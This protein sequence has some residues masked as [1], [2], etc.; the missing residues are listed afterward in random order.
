M[1][2]ALSWLILFYAITIKHQIDLLVG[3]KST[4]ACVFGAAF[5]RL[6]SGDK[7]SFV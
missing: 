4:A 1:I 7:S 6:A 5:E 3:R 2:P